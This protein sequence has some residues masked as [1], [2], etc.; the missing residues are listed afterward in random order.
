MTRTVTSFLLTFLLTFAFTANPAQAQSEYPGAVYDGLY[1]KAG[2]GISDYTGDYPIQNLGYPVDFQEF[3]R[4]GGVPWMYNVESGY[5]LSSNFAV[6]LGFQGGSYPIVQYGTTAPQTS[7]GS[8]RYTPH[9]LGRYT[10]NP[11]GSP[12]FYLDGG[13]NVT[14]G[15]GGTADTGYGPSVGGGV[16]FPIGS[17]MTFYVESRFHFTTPDDA[18]DDEADI[19]DTPSGATSK[20]ND[21]SGSTTGP[22][23][24]V[25]QLLGFGI[26]YSLT[27]STPPRVISLDGPSSAETGESVTYTATVNEEEADRPLSYR[28]TFGDGSTGSG[29]TTSHAYNQPGTYTV[30]FT[31]SNSAG[32]AS[33]SLQIDIVQPSQPAQIASVN[34]SPNPAE[35]GETVRFS[36]N[37][38]GDTPI[39]RNW[40]FGDGVS[41]MGESPTH[42]YQEP[43]QY[44]ARLEASNEAGQDSRT[45]TVRVNR[46]LPE[47]CTTIGELNSAFFRQNSS[48]LT[49]EAEGSLEENA[50][51]LS[52][53]PNL[54]VRVEAFAAPG[55][56]NPQSLSEDRAEAVAEFY[57]GNGVPEDR[58]QTMGEGQVEGV[59][60]KK[61]GT[62]QYR[63]ADSIPENEEGG[64]M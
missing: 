5:Q 26:K 4:G 57:E 21:P 41:A 48:T 23:D 17:A 24:S 20:T 47:V 44:T 9:L 22:F 34:A 10:F 46:V 12:A 8:Y 33:E 11:G 58:V 1:L 38:S 56:R 42:T 7:G 29:M 18:I 14:F 64:G 27:S 54:S 43:G 15:G 3:L 30:N 19:G 36:S 45:V 49:E 62:R 53:C 63:R 25:N 13:V 52:K 37:V 40:S 59:T 6:A 2:V 55:E 60:S 32:E 39:D 31:A 61:G 50:D 16:D 28:W 35:E 51:V